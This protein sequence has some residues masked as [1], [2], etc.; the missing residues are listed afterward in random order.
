MRYERELELAAPPDEAFA[1]MAEF[2]NG[3]EWDPSVVELNRLTPAP[4]ALG[5]RF[6]IVFVFRG[7]RQTMRYEVVEYEEGARMVLHGEGAKVRS[8]DTMTFAPTENGSRTRMRYAADIRLKGIYRLG[9]PFVRGAVKRASDE[10]F[11]RL[12]QR[13]AG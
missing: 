12:V 8:D 11:D 10:A 13:F 5:S 3:K 1:Y 6:E 7:N 2:E 4:T 9:D